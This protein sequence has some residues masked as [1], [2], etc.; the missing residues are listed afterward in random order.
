MFLKLLENKRRDKMKL[1][2]LMAAALVVSGIGANVLA[3]DTPAAG[4]KIALIDLQKALKDTKD[5]QAVEKKLKT[6]F[7]AKKKE[8]EKKQAALQDL[9]KDLEKRAMGMSDEV[10]IQ[11]Q[12]ELQTEQI[13]FQKEVAESQMEIQKKERDLTK[14]ILDKIASSVDKVA[15]EKGMDIVLQKNDMTVI[16]SKNSL[17]ITDDVVKQYA[18][19]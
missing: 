15:K 19:K 13:K 14:P 17:D 12:R 9:A 8:F 16:W 4:T 5:G 11:K 18:K 3:A 1:A 2:I 6:E 10:R 7:D